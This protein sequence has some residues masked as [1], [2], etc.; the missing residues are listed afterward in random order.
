M[1]DGGQ[2]ENGRQRVDYYKGVQ[3]PWNMMP[4]YQLN[5]QNAFNMHKRI[6][7]IIKER[8]VAIEERDRALSERNAAFDERDMAF[9]QRDTAIVERDNALR[10][11]DNAIAALQFHETTMKSTLSCG[12]QR[13]TKRVHRPINHPTSVAEAA[14]NTREGHIT[15]AFPVSAISSEVVKSRQPKRETES[16]V[17]SPTTSKSPKKRKKIGEDL[18]RRV[19]T[20]GSKAEWDSQDFD[21]MNQVNFDDSTMPVPFCSCTGERRQCYKWGNGGW[22]SSCCTTTLSVY[23][24]PQMPNKR[25]A[26][27]GGRKMSG[28]VFTRLLNQLAADG[29]DVSVPLDLKN[30]WA[31]H[32]TNRYITIK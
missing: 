22:Q 18:N 5:D 27:M 21:L 11:R 25:H 29:H 13:G 12:I 26:R 4:Q 19:T 9:Q 10:E 28:S 3:I 1:D 20:H 30:Y 14:Y 6:V 23:P 15:D 17:V 8:S 16:K 31:K 24:L 32:G 7:N 2:R